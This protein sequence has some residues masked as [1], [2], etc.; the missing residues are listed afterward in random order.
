MNYRERA[1]EV[2]L[3][4]KKQQNYNENWEGH[5]RAVAKVAAKVAEQCGMDANKTYALG[6]LHDIGRCIGDDVGLEHPVVG[7]EI[8]K[9]RGMLEAAKVSMTHTYYGYEKIDRKDLLTVV[10]ERE[11]EENGEGREKKLGVF[12]PRFRDARRLEFTIHFMET[13]ELDDYDRLI[14][15]ADNMGHSLGIMTI[16][17]RFCDI[18]LRHHLEKPWENLSCLYEL[19]QYFDRKAGMNI[20]ELFKE[21]IMKTALREPN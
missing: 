20:Y 2:F 16:S 7:F 3:W 19:K 21:E 12:G 14:Q 1:E 17:D 11:L 10:G 5:S 13:V 4:G 15:L 9:E 8:L 18:M 6:L